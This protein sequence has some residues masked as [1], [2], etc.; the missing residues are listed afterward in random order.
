MA[1]RT[2]FENR[3]TVL[4]V[5][6][7]SGLQENLAQWLEDDGIEVMVCPGPRAPQF[8]CIGFRGQPCP[9]LGGADL[10]V[11]DLHPEPGLLLDRT[12]RCDLLKHYQGYGRRVVAVVEAGNNLDF[13]DATGVATV[14]RFAERAVFLGTV[15]EVLGTHRGAS[16]S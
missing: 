16:P 9:L 15:R 7:D 12:R 4:V 14:E 5:S 8:S 1:M 13:P 3:N 10:V 2:Q 11:V 6:E